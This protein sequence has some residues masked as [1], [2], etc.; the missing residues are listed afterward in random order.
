MNTSQ[1]N[2]SKVDERKM[3]DQIKEDGEKPGG[4]EVDT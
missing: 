4:M 3:E 2:D 1:G